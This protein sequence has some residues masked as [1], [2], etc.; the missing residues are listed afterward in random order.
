MYPE[1]NEPA[2]MYDMAK[3]HKFG[4]T[5]NIKLTKLK[6]RP[7]NDQTGTYTYTAAKVIS[8]HLKPLCQS[9]YIIKDTQSFAKLI[10]E[11]PPFQEDKENVSYDIE[12]LFTNI[13]IHDTIDY[14]LEQIYV[15]YKL[16]PICSKLIFKHLLIKLSTEVTFTFTSKFC[17]QTDASNRWLYH[18]RSFQQ[19]LVIYT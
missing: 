19:H 14:I 5:D 18:G 12:F 8:L 9:E 1:S 3:T 11:L 2:K 10:K 7:I 16:K 4:S 13:P 15:P 17:K 6:F